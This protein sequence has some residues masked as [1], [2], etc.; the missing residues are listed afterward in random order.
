MTRQQI[1]IFEL[2]LIFIILP[3]LYYFN[4]LPIPKMAGLLLVASYCTGVLWVDKEFKVSQLSHRPA[5]PGMWKKLALKSLIIALAVTALT[6]LTQ[7]AHLFQ[8][9]RRHPILW[10]AII[11]LYPLLSVI[12]QEIIYRVFFFHRYRKIFTPAWLMIT[13][14][15]CSF[16]FLHIVYHNGWAISFALIGGFL[17]ARNYH[18][19]HSL[20][21]VCVE[22][23]LYGWIIFTVGMGHYFYK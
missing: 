17:F 7:P 4:L 5:V 20:Y 3:A 2:L 22:H 10:I 9:P 11:F 1:L 8:L 15:A 6:L 23:S 13:S 12:P 21:W 16:S 14:S 19:N 18:K